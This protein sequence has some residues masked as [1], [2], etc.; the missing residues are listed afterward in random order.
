M[1]LPVSALYVTRVFV[2]VRECQSV[3][4]TT[5]VCATTCVLYFSGGRGSR[6]GMDGTV[7]VMM[8]P[9]YL[10]CRVELCHHSLLNVMVQVPS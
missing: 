2:S 7:V 5:C 10:L 1:T 9:A 4:V 8:L 3:C 6:Y